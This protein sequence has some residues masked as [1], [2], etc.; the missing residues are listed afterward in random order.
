MRLFLIL[1]LVF[2][3]S[4]VLASNKEKR[5]EQSANK[6]AKIEQP[7]V[8]EKGRPVDPGAHGRANAAQKQAVN[9]GKGPE[10]NKDLEVMPLTSKSDEAKEKARTKKKKE[11]DGS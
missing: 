5:S 2:S 3:V 11:S 1:I 7:Y 8:K 6:P 9:P 10:K 4:A